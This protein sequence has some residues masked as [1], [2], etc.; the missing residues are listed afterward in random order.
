M[1]LALEGETEDYSLGRDLSLEGADR[2][3]EMA[4]RHGF[5]PAEPQWYGEHLTALD[6]ER[7]ADAYQ[8]RRANETAGDG[9][10]KIWAAE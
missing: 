2:I 4:R 9:Q 3:A 6:F 7:T 5:E 8:A 10:R 1:L